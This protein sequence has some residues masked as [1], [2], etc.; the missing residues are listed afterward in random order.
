MRKEYTGV[1]ETD[2]PNRAQIIRSKEG[3]QAAPLD[4]CF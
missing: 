4:D 1:F 2:N 3:R